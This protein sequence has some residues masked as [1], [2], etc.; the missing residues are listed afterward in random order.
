MMAGETDPARSLDY[1][2]GY[3]E[4]RMDALSE[5]F[6]SAWD[7][8]WRAAVSRIR[9]ETRPGS[10]PDVNN[11]PPLPPSD[12][13]PEEKPEMRWMCGICGNAKFYWDVSRFGAKG[14]WW[15]C[16]FCEDHTDPQPA[17]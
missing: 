2:D 5:S 12:P 9:E 13:P 1:R 3:A 11:G 7:A 10:L 15:W 6:G 4:G 14:A 16:Y 17:D 8:G